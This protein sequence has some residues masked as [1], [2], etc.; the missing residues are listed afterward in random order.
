MK[1]RKFLAI[2][3]ALA[4][5]LSL[6][7]CGEDKK[8]D[9]TSKTTEQSSIEESSI[10]STETVDLSALHT[11][12]ELE[13]L[14]YS[15]ILTLGEYKNIISLE[16]SDYDVT[17]EELQSEID[18][19]LDYYG[20]YTQI[21][22]TACKSGD[23]VNIDFAGKIN[24]E[25]FSGGTAT[26]Q[27]LELGS[28]SYVDGFEDGVIGMK[29][30]ETKTINITFPEDYGNEELNGKEAVFDVT[31]N[32]IC[33]EKI[34][35]E[36]TDDFVK[37][38]TSGDYSTTKEFSDYVSSYIYANK[39]QQ[40][41]TKFIAAMLETTS[42]DGDIT[43]YVEDEYNEGVTYYTDYAKS[44]DQDLATFAT[45]CGYE[46]EDALLDYIKEDAENYV[47][48]K[49]II[50]AIGQELDYTLT[51]DEYDNGAQEIVD[52]YGYGDLSSLLSS[53]RTNVIRYDIYSS[54]I[55]EKIIELN[56]GEAVNAPTSTENIS[57]TTETTEET[58]QTE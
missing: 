14:D 53:Y 52:L 5:T 10:E 16:E 2:L 41:L 21:T 22:D 39:K 29:A 30:G 54:K 48:T 42:F 57:E 28:N 24:G 51:D 27:Q 47:K 44:L 13:S 43:K 55:A 34:K 6:V 15:K 3:L 11:A 17:D 37:E 35:A 36:F 31:L 9:D 4:T 25:S 19:Y 38:I 46:S 7:A 12:D 32:Y 26:D 56:K 23:T 8:T 1:K 49:M 20:E 45:S 58:T 18:Y 40:V 50:Y 33:G